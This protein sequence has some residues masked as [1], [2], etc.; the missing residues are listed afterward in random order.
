MKRL[1][2]R[3]LLT[4]SKNRCQRKRPRQCNV[5]QMSS[6]ISRR[7]T[8]LSTNIII[9]ETQESLRKYSSKWLMQPVAGVN[10][11]LRSLLKNSIEL[12]RNCY[13]RNSAMKIP[14]LCFT[15]LNVESKL[16]TSMTAG[17][18]YRSRKFPQSSNSSQI[19]REISRRTL[20]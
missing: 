4:Q 3:I 16:D 1:R 13:S 11:L 19:T 9:L 2:P 17:I 10:L 8:L 7:A 6:G 15:I 12:V 18:V 14:I 5:H 20:I